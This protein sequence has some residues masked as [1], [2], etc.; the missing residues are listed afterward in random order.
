[1]A[2]NPTLPFLLLLSYASLPPDKCPPTFDLKTWIKE[3]T[4]KSMK[5]GK[6]KKLPMLHDTTWHISQKN[7]LEKHFCFQ[8]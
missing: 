5:A 8:I 3:H 1:V 2:D 7:N 4:D 6:V